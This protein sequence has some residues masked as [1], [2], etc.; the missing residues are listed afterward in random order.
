MVVAAAFGQI[1]DVGF[2]RLFQDDIASV[3]EAGCGTESD[4]FQF[5]AYINTQTCMVAAISCHDEDRWGRT[6]CRESTCGSI[7]TAWWKERGCREAAT[8]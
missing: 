7:A 1:P 6:A 4:K 2:R 8:V 3:V 5:R